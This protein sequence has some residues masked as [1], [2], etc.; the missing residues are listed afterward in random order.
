MSTSL[1]ICGLYVGHQAPL[2]MRFS[3]QE[4]W[5][6]LPFPCPGDSPGD[7]PYP[8]TELKSLRSPALAGG[9]FTT[10][11]TWEAPVTSQRERKG[12]KGK[13]KRLPFTKVLL[14]AKRIHRYWDFPSG[15]WLRLHA[16]NAGGLSSIPGQETR[17]HMPQLKILHAETKSKG[18]A[19]CN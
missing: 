2:S 11:D 18:L 10:S 15:Q 12:K 16:P 6:A 1:R 8:E 3:R 13:E 9:Y 4:Y 14:C 5:N 19:C 17:S 7:I